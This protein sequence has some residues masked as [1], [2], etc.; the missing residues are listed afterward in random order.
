MN[1]IG[2]F[3]ITLPQAVIVVL[4]VVR[5]AFDVPEMLRTEGLEYAGLDITLF[6]TSNRRLEGGKTVPA[7]VEAH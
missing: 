7:G 2:S 3:R 1:N 6:D 5:L 4:C